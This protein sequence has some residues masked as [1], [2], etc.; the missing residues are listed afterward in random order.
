MR[1]K[2]ER[3]VHSEKAISAARIAKPMVETVL[4]LAWFI[5]LGGALTGQNYNGDIAFDVFLARIGGAASSHATNFLIF[6]SIFP[7]ALLVL[8]SMIPA[9]LIE[10]LAF[11]IHEGLWQIPYAIAWHSVIS[12]RIWFL[13]NALGTV[14]TVATVAILM[15]VYHLPSRFFLA[16]TIAW[17]VFLSAWLALG[18]P[19]TALSK[20]PNFQVAPS[21]Y[22]SILWVNQVEFLGWLYFASVLLVCLQYFRLKQSR[23]S[24]L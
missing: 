5:Y 10:A 11:E 2:I 24:T 23:K 1:K 13:E 8:R 4:V 20:L 7:I 22:N 6:L 12:W 14:A 16:V 21:V 3:F 9:F 18:F 15:T 17:G 19:V